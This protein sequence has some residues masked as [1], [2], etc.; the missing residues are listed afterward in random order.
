MKYDNFSSEISSPIHSCLTNVVVTSK[1]SKQEKFI[2]II[3]TNTM[4]LITFNCTEA[5]Y[6]VDG[7]S[8]TGLDLF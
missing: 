8:G 6:C 2:H 3:R 4:C 1:Q 7:D 5:Y